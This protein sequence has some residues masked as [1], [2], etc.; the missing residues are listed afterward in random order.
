MLYAILYVSMWP[1]K[2]ERPYHDDSTASR[3]LS[4]VKHHRARLVLRWGTTLESRVLFFCHPLS[5][6]LFPC[7]SPC[8]CSFHSFYFFSFVSYCCFLLSCLI[9]Y[10]LLLHSHMHSCITLTL[11]LLFLS[12]FTITQWLEEVLWVGCTTHHN[13]CAGA[14]ANGEGLLSP[15]LSYRV[16]Q[17]QQTHLRSSRGILQYRYTYVHSSRV[18]TIVLIYIHTTLRRNIVVQTN[19]P[20]EPKESYRAMK[21]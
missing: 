17:L 12:T 18:Y 5:F 1:Y 21:Q 10:F 4:E 15:F 13:C 19:I 8:F 6:C 2:Q 11:H 16:V 3:L 9:S 20:T 14:M 7:S